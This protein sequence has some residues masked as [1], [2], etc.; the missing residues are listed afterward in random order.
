MDVGSRLLRGRRRRYYEDTTSEILVRTFVFT[1]FMLGIGLLIG[2]LLTALMLLWMDQSH[3]SNS[4]LLVRQ[5]AFVN[6]ELSLYD[7]D[8]NVSYVLPHRIPE[9]DAPAAS[10]NGDRLAFSMWTA[11][12][13]QHDI[14]MMD[15]ATQTFYSL[16][17]RFNLSVTQPA[18]SPEGNYLA[19]TVRNLNGQHDIYQLDVN[20]GTFQNLTVRVGDNISPDWSPDGSSIVF[21]ARRSEESE[22]IHIY[23][24]D[25]DDETIT[26]LTHG[27]QNFYQPRWSPDGTLV[28]FTSIRNLFVLDVETG[29]V[30]QLTNNLSENESQQLLAPIWSPDS[31]HIA[32]V[33]AVAWERDLYIIDRN[34]NNL[35]QV[36]R[37]IRDFIVP[38]WSADS[39]SIA[40]IV[41]DPGTR[42]ERTIVADTNGEIL[43]DERRYDG[44]YAWIQ[45]ME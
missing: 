1:R 2:M 10:P 25:I 31:Q 22:F 45:W 20:R 7:L 38:D 9:L 11:Q 43:Y 34:G 18:W 27:E 19:V 41:H 39:Q 8:R 36:G 23:K 17:S 16:S 26:Q 6:H 37:Y 35:R 3:T 21:G 29:E 28:A 5:R 40:F 13:A 4:V 30:T 12:E 32:F 15:V 44:P 14:F 24:I 42:Y 33:S